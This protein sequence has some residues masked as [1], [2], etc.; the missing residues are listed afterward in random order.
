MLLAGPPPRSQV[1]APKKRRATDEDAV[2]RENIDDVL[3]RY[4]DGTPPFYMSVPG[5]AMLAGVGDA[6]GVPA[7]ARVMQSLSKMKHIEKDKQGVCDFYWQNGS[8]ATTKQRCYYIRPGHCVGHK[9]REQKAVADLLRGGA[10]LNDIRAHT[11]ALSVFKRKPALSDIAGLM[12]HEGITQASAA[13]LAGSSAASCAWSSRAARAGTSSCRSGGNNGGRNGPSSGS[14]G[15]EAGG[16]THGVLQGAGAACGGGSP[17]LTLLGVAHDE[18]LHGGGHLGLAIVELLLSRRLQLADETRTEPQAAE[19]LLWVQKQ[20]LRAG[21]AKALWPSVLRDVS[22]ATHD[23]GGGRSAIDSQFLLRVWRALPATPRLIIKYQD[24]KLRPL[25]EEATA[26]LLGPSS[27]SSMRTPPLFD[28]YAALQQLREPRTQLSRAPAALGPHEL[29]NKAVVERYLEPRGGLSDTWMA[30]LR[31]I[32]M[33]CGVSLRYMN[34]IVATL[35]RL[36]TGGDI[37]ACML[38]STRTMRAGFDRIHDLDRTLARAK[39]MGGARWYHVSQ[40]GVVPD[41]ETPYYCKADDH[42]HVRD[43]DFHSSHVSYPAETGPANMLVT[44]KHIAQTDAEY[45][46]AVDLAA[47]NAAGFTGTSEGGVADGAALAEIRKTCVP[48]AA[49]PPERFGITKRA[50]ALWDPPHKVAVMAKDFSAAAFGEPSGDAEHLHHKQAAY[51]WWHTFQAMPSAY[52]SLARELKQEVMS[53][54][55]ELGEQSRE[56]LREL[57]RDPASFKKQR[58]ATLKQ[59]CGKLLALLGLG[60]GASAQQYKCQAEQL[61]L[62]MAK[63]IDEFLGG[64]EAILRASNGSDSRGRLGKCA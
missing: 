19:L 2:P 55:S 20:R 60:R 42:H 16:S 52:K 18:L 3:R 34:P 9:M 27:S 28:T 32:S 10:T 26:A 48:D 35:Y 45:A 51:K 47:A 43:H 24:E 25:L 23:L 59:A 38:A 13:R 41:G 54:A 46:A 58:W 36:F 53:G 50:V 7:A 57:T 44:A 1:Q 62:D 8:L 37:P 12:V 61:V 56:I 5:L 17:Q 31:S 4:C 11:D 6:D 40:G 64:D 33:G 63:G 39:F 29:I 15:S 21:R 49:S 22:G 30:A 14:N